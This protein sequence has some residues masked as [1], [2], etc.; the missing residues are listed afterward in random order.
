LPSPHSFRADY[1]IGAAATTEHEH[2][3]RLTRGHGL[4]Y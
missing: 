2:A 1:R 3:A 4:A